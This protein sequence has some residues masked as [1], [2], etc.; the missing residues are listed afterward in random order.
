MF[1]SLLSL[2][3]LAATSTA[4]DDDY[5]GR[6][7]K[8]QEQVERSEQTAQQLCEARQ[9]EAAQAWGIVESLADSGRPEGLAAL[10]EFV[11]RYMTP[12]VV[13]GIPVDC[14]IES[15]S[16]AR[17]LHGSTNFLSVRTVP[18]GATV[19][20]DGL[21]MGRSPFVSNRLP[22]GKHMVRI[23]LEGHRAETR[24]VEVQAGE[25]VEL[26]DIT[27]QPGEPGAE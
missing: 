17:A 18:T 19:L 26:H 23:E 5:L 10:A 2:S 15:L 1:G 9:A 4:Q 14:S 12:L 21:A 7:R 11:D 6:L 20:V 13:D 27:L 16:L 3:L 8:L 24:L 25:I 22:E